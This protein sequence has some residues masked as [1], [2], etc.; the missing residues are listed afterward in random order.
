MLEAL[1]AGMVVMI[2]VVNISGMPGL[3]GQPDM[4]SKGYGIL[5]DLYIRD[6]L[7][8]YT[9]ARD[10]TGLESEVLLFGYNHSVQICDPY[11]CVG[12]VPEADNVWTAS[13]IVAGEDFPDPANVK[14]YIW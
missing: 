4:S 14:L 11:G 5:K 8:N 2:F 13:Y 7:R 12:T 10:F 6:S 1:I 3:A 9:A